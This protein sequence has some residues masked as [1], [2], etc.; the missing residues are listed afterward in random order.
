M[1][2]IYL[3]GYLIIAAFLYTLNFELFHTSA[4]LDLGFGIF[5]TFPL[6]IEM[7]IGLLFCL[8][9]FLT[10]KNKQIKNEAHIENLKNEIIIHKKDLEIATLKRNTSTTEPP[11]VAIEEI[12]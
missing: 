11:I 2:N 7:V 6:V 12:N 1:R 9:F 8:L 4:D 3:L 5:T 10:D